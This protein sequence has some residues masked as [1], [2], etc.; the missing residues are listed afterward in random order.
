VA[1]LGEAAR[2]ATRRRWAR[3]RGGHVEE[4]DVA[5]VVFFSCLDATLKKPFQASD[6]PFDLATYLTPAWRP[7]K[8]KTYTWSPKKGGRRREPRLFRPHS[9]IPS[10]S[11]GQRDRSPWRVVRRSPC[12]RT[13]LCVRLAVAR[14]ELSAQARRRSEDLAPTASTTRESAALCWPIVDGAGRARHRAYNRH[15]TGRARH[16]KTTLPPHR[17]SSRTASSSRFVGGA[18]AGVRPFWGWL[19]PRIPYSGLVPL[20]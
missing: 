14:F 3:R 6:P 17:A 16:P 8:K 12:S 4:G 13:R 5:R 10:E 2:R 7:S 11:P 9:H 18:P 1:A 19:I 20:D 15:D